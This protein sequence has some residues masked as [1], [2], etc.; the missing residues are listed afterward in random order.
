MQKKARRGRFFP[1]FV[2]IIIIAGL[3]AIGGWFWLNGEIHR[4]YSHTA[5]QKIIAIEPGASTSVILARLQR[6]G[7][8]ESELPVKLWLRLFE[9]GLSFKAGDYMF[10]SPISPLQVIHQLARGE[11]ATRQFTIPEGYNQ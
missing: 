11:V 5:A 4:S 10:K 9:P 7:I 3:A 1:K 6:E 2:A 8:L